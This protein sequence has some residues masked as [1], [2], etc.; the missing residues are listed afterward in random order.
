MLRSHQAPDDPSIRMSAAPERVT[1]ARHSGPGLR[2]IMWVQG[3][4]LLCTRHC[5]NPHLLRDEGG[6]LVPASRLAGALLKLARDYTEVEGVTVLGGE[7]LD[8]ASALAHALM[9]VRAAGLSIMVYTG[10][11]LES[12]RAS[13]ESGVARLLE[14]CDIL[15]DGPFIDELY[16][17]SLIW[18][19]STNQR[20]LRLSERYTVEDIE[21]ALAQ[22]RRAM[23]VSVNTRGDVAVSGAQNTDAAHRL[24]Q[25]TRTPPRRKKTLPDPEVEL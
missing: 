17:E 15:V 5:L 10:H 9:P 1:L 8:Q 18:R 3:C 22:Q 6:H 16:D 19:G 24:R 14:L 13:Q 23:A 11:T 7:P 4:N 2:L 12:L 25:L 20:I 21:R